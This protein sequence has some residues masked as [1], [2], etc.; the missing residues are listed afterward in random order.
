MIL[1][2]EH[3]KYVATA[4]DFLRALDEEHG[5]GGMGM[6]MGMGMGRRGGN[7]PSSQQPYYYQPHGGG[8]G[9]SMRDMLMGGGGGGG[10]GGPVVEERF[11][12]LQFAALREPVHF[13]R[14][15]QRRYLS[16]TT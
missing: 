4:L 1:L 8:G 2:A 16:S 7:L 12:S 3:V 13:P 10:G 6:G 14:R 9:G 5:G 15:L 11:A